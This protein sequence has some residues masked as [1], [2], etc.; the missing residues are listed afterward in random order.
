MLWQS[1]FPWREGLFLGKALDI[2]LNV[3][4]ISSPISS[5]EEILQRPSPWEPGGISGGKDKNMHEWGNPKTAIPGICHSLATRIQPLVVVVV[6]QLLSRVQLFETPWTQHSR[7][8][9][10][11]PSPRVHPS[12][13]PV[14]QWC[15]LTVS[16]SA[17]SGSSP[18]IASKCSYQVWFQWLC[19]M[20]GKTW[21]LY[22]SGCGC[23]IRFLGVA[24]FLNLF[25]LIC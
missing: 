15:Y 14:Y 11:S 21:V 18:K 13:C 7:P 19:S 23:L 6:V 3:L 17:T 8:L 10:P 9:C 4:G 16:S 2:F 5:H 25:F 1:S 22:L 12:S 24:L 20:E